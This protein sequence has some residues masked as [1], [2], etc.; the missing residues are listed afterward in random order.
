MSHSGLSLAEHPELGVRCITN[1]PFVKE[2]IAQCEFYDL[3]IEQLF[4]KAQQM[5]LE[6]HTLLSHPLYSNIRGDIS[7]YKCLLLSSTKTETVDLESWKLLMSAIFY[8][9]QLKQLH[10]PI[11]WQAEYLEDFQEVDYAI[12]SELLR[13]E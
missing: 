13:L 9:R 6:G 1:N 3:E 11:Q 2:K 10:P 8:I 5:I 7:P 4:V 12:I